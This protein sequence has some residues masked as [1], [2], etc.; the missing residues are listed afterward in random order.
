VLAPDQASILNNLA[1]AHAMEGHP[2]KAEPLLK[3]AAAAGGHEA[4]V[5]QNL[6]LVLGLQGRYDEAKVAAARD[7]PVDNAAANV[8]YVRRM[9]KLDPK[10][11]P[12]V[13]AP[14]QP[15]LKG[16]ATADGAVPEGASGWAPQV[17]TAKPAR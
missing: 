16:T 12:R 15:E 4:R 6:A 1:L 14:P 2:D 3:R 10:S 13:A 5:S 7:L 8:D 11:P 17:A 9:V